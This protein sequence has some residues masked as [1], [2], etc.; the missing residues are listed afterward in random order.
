[1]TNLRK[2]VSLIIAIIL[3]YIVHEGSHIIVAMLYGAFDG[4]RFLGLGV[5][6]EA[7]VEILSRLQIV[8][9]CA[10]GSISTLL[11]AYLLVLFTNKIVKV[12]N[13]MVR[14]IFYYTTLVFLLLDPLYL[15][16]VYKFVGGGDMNGILL[17][18]FSDFYIQIFFGVILVINIILIIKK[19]Y[20]TYK[21][22]FS[23]K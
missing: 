6:V 7:K 1:M 2:W 20:P 12:N 17:L 10:I 13:K 9:F 11:V 5:Q 19:I 4:I 8:F 3:Y 21:D 23:E 14:A 18:G 15:S 22:S 16:I